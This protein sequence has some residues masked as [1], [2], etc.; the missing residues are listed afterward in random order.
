MSETVPTPINLASARVLITNDDGIEAEGLKRLEATVAPLVEE[1]WTVA[2]D[3]GRSAAS[4]MVSLRKHLEIEQRGARRFAVSGS[5]ADCS[6]VALQHVMKDNPPDLVL[7]GINLGANVGIDVHFSGTVGAAT[8][9]ASNGIP[10]IALSA[11]DR[12]SPISAEQWDRTLPFLP[13]ALERACRTGFVPGTLYNI[14]LPE[15]IADP[16]DPIRIAFQGVAKDS[17]VLSAKP[18][19]GYRIDHTGAYGAAL[20]GSDLDLMRKGYISI[21]P[22]GLDRTDRTLMDFLERSG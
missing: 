16:A 8:Y 5:P 2:P 15:E 3:G 14:N 20:E 13:A 11:Q 10:S 7:S 18:E 1:M 4:A 17:F 6:L 12:N 22:I 19:G 21:A 9:A